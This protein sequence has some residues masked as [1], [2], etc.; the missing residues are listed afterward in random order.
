[1]AHD[2]GYDLDRLR[3]EAPAQ[4]RSYAELVPRTAHLRIEVLNPTAQFSVGSA[5]KPVLIVCG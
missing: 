2:Q 1:L 3:R 4:Y 5:T